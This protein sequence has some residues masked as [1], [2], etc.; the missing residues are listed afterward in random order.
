M[1]LAGPQPLA[2]QQRHGPLR[3]GDVSGL[4]GLDLLGVEAHA[5]ELE[6]GGGCDLE[7]HALLTGL[8]RDPRR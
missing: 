8:F 7:A 6:T 1:G 5:A 4:E 2:G 3:L